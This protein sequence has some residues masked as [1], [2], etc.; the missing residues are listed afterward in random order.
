[1][2]W[3]CYDV[4]VVAMAVVPVVVISWARLLWL[5]LQPCR[6]WPLSH[7]KVVMVITE[8]TVWV[9]LVLVWS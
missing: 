5:R 9:V 3:S 7:V 4:L 8:A 2:S 1:M 6:A